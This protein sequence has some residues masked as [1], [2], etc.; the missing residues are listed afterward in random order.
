MMGFDARWQSECQKCLISTA[1]G[2]PLLGIIC[3]VGWVPFVSLPLALVI[4]GVAD[5][6]VALGA[7]GNCYYGAGGCR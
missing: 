6:A 1:N 5:A 2:V 7:L 3:V 4:C